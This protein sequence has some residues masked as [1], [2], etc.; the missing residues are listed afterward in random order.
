MSIRSQVSGLLRKM[1]LLSVAEQTRFYLQKIKYKNDNTAFRKEHPEFILPPEFFVYETYR[2]NYKWY[3]EDGKNTAQEIVTLF[4]KHFDINKEDVR[5]LDWGCGPGRVVRHL[6]SFLSHAEI[7]G[8]DY[9]EDYIKWCSENLKEINFSINKV[10]PP[11]N[12]SDSFFNAVTGLS[13]F[14][15]LSEPN[16]FNWIA[17][18]YRI[19]KPGGGLYITTQGNAYY[20]KLTSVEKDQFDSNLPVIRKFMDEGNRLYSSFQPAGFMK[21]II[22]GKFQLVEFM[23]GQIENNEPAQDIWLLRKI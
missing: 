1:N 15:H 8:T 9:N 23:E 14:T 20:S 3:Y 17:E 19:I 18:L 13:I 22:D 11:T 10:D 16:H 7:Y 6:P 5:I 4:S 12:F 2:L 21:K